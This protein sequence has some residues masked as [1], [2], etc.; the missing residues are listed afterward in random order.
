MGFSPDT[1]T[2]LA[3]ALAR[4]G[5]ADEVESLVAFGI[6]GSVFYVDGT[7]G[8]DTDDGLSWTTAKKTI[9]DALDACTSGNGDHVVVLPGTYAE[10]LVLT[11]KHNVHLIAVP[12]HG[13][14]KRVAV[15]PA[16]GI[17]LDLAQSNRFVAR[18]IRFVGTS[19]VG[20]RSDGEGALFEDCD[21]TSDTSHGLEFLAATDTDFTGSGTVFQ[22]CIFRECGG[23]GLRLSV[24][25]G[26]A[27]GLNATNVNVLDSQFY[28][29][30]GDDIDDDAGAGSPTYFYQWEITGNRF[31]T[32]NKTVYLDMDGGVTA[33]CLIAGNYFADDAGLDGTKIALATGAVFSGNFQAAG[34]VDGSTF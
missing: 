10:N 28:L 24:G 14:S 34:V 13:N 26:V 9:Q 2:R 4:P 7:N 25:T 31:M 6:P 30:T 20:C 21:F 12:R 8:L 16:S 29:N 23:A 32:R 1:K 22:R 18:G 3:Y 17:G 19:A 33:E 5:A 11:A 15:A 27:L